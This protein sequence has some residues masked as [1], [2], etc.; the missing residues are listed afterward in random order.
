M[1]PGF[2]LFGLLFLSPWFGFVLRGLS[3]FFVVL[4]LGLCL[5]FCLHNFW[6]FGSLSLFFLFFMI[7]EFR[8]LC[9]SFSLFVHIR[10]SS[11]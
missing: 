3:L 1:P 8:L 7:S 5:G 6:V 2:D 9:F 11:L 10:N 4:F